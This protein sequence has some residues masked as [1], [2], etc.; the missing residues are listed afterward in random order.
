[1]ATGRDFRCLLLAFS[2]ATCSL[3]QDVPK[4]SSQPAAAT[5]E[6]VS[7]TEVSAVDV[8]ALPADSIGPPLLCD[9]DGT[10]LRRLAAPQ[11]GVEDPVSRSKD[12]KT[13]IRFGSEKINDIPR[14]SFLH[15]FVNGSDVYFG[16]REHSTWRPGQTADQAR[17][18]SSAQPQEAA[19]S[20]RSWF[21]AHFEREGTYVGAISLNLPFRPLRLGA[22]QNGD[23][24]LAGAEPATDEPRLAV[25][26]S[27]GQLRRFV[28]LKEDVR[29]QEDEESGASGEDKDPTA[30]PRFRPPQGRPSQSF[31]VTETLRGVVS[32]SKIAQDRAD[33][34]LFR[35]INGP[36]FPLRPRAKCEFAN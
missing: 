23:L 9:P 35:P 6:R 17:R 16:E 27:N 3:A 15:M 33:L 29:A 24:L 2:A 12:G 18:K 26:A 1:M 8:P 21:I 22:F 25:V 5:P 28:E 14:P 7:L 11:G 10:I 13:A 34:L 36:Y 19:G 30:L 32:T 20:S 4:H 31:A